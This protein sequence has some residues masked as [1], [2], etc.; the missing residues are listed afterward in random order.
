MMIMK[1]LF[2]LFISFLPISTFAL[3]LINDFEWLEPNNSVEVVV[4]EPYQLKFNCSDNS[5]PFTSDYA[6]YWNHYDFAGGQ[7]IVSTPTG[8]SIDEK[9]VITGINPGS[10]AIKFT[11]YIQPKS[12]VDKMLMI[13]VVSERSET[14]SNNTLDTANDITNKIRFGLFNI[15]DI[16]YFKLTN[17]NLKWGDNVTFKIHYY[18]SRENPFG[19]KW[20]TFCGGDMVG[21][22]SL[23]SQDQE[24]KALVSSGNTVYL[25]VYYDQS[26]SQYFNYGEEFV[27]EVFVN[28][29][30][31]SEY[32]NDV[33]EKFEGEG[34]ESVP[35]LIK[36]ALS[37]KKLSNFVNSGNSYANTYF[38]LSNNI[39]MTGEAFEPIGNQSN[40]FSGIFD[41]KGFVIKGITVNADSY[42]G[43]F[44]YIDNAYINDVGVED[45]S[46]TGSS[47]LGGIAGYSQNSVITNCFTRGHTNGNDCVGA[48]VGFSGE[49]TI[50]RNCFSSMQHT[51]YQIYGSVGG[52]VG[53]NCGK[54][55]N[56]YFYGTIN[57]KIFEKSSTGGIVGYNHTTGAIHYCYFIK[58]G[59][60]MN[61]EFNYCG[62]LNWGDCYGTDSFDFNGLTTSGQYLHILLNTWVTDHS[63]EGH[64][65]KWTSEGFPV[66]SEY[67]EPTEQNENKE[68]VDLALPS[69][70]LWASANLGA[71]RPEEPGNYYAWGETTPNKSVYDATTYTD[72]NVSIISGTEY[73]AAYT[74]SGGKCRIPT[75]DEFIEL[76][77]YCTWE[78]TQVNSINGYKVI[79]ANGNSIFLPFVGGKED[80]YNV[81]YSPYGYSGQGFY[82]SGTAFQYDS[83]YNWYLY[84]DTDP[85]YGMYGYN[86]T[87]GQT[88]RPVQN[89]SSHI[90]GIING[91]T[92]T[93]T[94]IYSL[95]GRLVRRNANLKETIKNLPSGIYI[96][97]GKKFIVK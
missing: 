83:N 61:G 56:S 82:V 26:H 32:G 34:T 78:Y 50:V 75:Y 52:L 14:E 93:S 64:Y 11:G 86:K 8:Y 19:Y 67:V 37:L 22:G 88:I 74:T 76:I 10:Y 60:V 23:I 47:H 63:N 51:K 2:A 38:E 87:R 58:Y 27:A 45:A 54:I 69:G 92:A 80:S 65:R 84:M 95:D 79:G 15:S 28:G 25:E 43:L 97:N 49:G 73:D 29:I 17:K 53:Y 44:G 35:Y 9:G 31:A 85:R 57:A 89:L 6:D 30:P 90:D 72:P 21:G 33:S 77:N 3:S 36:D 81:G 94:N 40:H 42:L 4:G 66:F 39:D 13:T 12:G 18:G 1:K 5:L 20:A 24:C 96:A 62:S 71:Q 55:E 16:D 7:H 46:F 91:N 59:D 70:L 41:G 68:Y 48:L